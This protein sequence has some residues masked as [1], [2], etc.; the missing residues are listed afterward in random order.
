MLAVGSASAQE[1][2]DPSCT[3]QSVDGLTVTVEI[4]DMRPYSTGEVSFFNGEYYFDE[5]SNLLPNPFTYLGLENGVH[6]FTLIP[7]EWTVDFA[8]WTSS[9]DGTPGFI[10]GWGCDLTSLVIGEVDPADAL[11]VRPRS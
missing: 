11:D 8:E 5:N 2:P 4:A 1:A 7:G 9:A 6:E 10:I 3:I